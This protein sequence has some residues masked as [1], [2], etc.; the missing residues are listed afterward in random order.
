MVLKLGGCKMVNE[1]VEFF[2]KVNQQGIDSGCAN[3][4][5]DFDPIWVIECSG[6]ETAWVTG[7]ALFSW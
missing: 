5:L 4:P 3:W 1:G 6:Y 7:A 2:V